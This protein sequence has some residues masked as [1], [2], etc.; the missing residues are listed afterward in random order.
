[1]IFARASSV[2]SSTVRHKLDLGA[3]VAVC[4]KCDR[5]SAVACELTRRSMSG[6]GD[7]GERNRRGSGLSLRVRARAER[8]SHPESTASAPGRFVDPFQSAEP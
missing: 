5:T 7:R 4:W 6:W 1:V 2:K 8:R 3:V